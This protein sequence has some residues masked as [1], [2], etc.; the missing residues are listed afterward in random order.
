MVEIELERRPTRAVRRRREVALALAVTLSVAACVLV[1]A[2]SFS[3]PVVERPSPGIAIGVPDS[4]L[5]GDEPS[6][7]MGTPGPTEAP[8]GSGGSGGTAPPG[9]PRDPLGGDARTGGPEAAAQPAPTLADP[10]D[11]ADPADP[12]P[13][14]PSDEDGPVTGIVDPLLRSLG[15]TAPVAEPVRRIARGVTTCVDDL[16]ESLSSGAVSDCLLPVRG[17]SR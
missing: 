5:E 4:P 10:D 3:D 15:E 13:T 1:V 6:P 8:G 17:G 11:T 7:T 9:S 14:G 16:L 2:R 12:T